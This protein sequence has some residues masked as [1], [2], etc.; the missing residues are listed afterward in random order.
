[1]DSDSD[2]DSDDNDNDEDGWGGNTLVE[3]V[4]SEYYHDKN[5]QY[6]GNNDNKNK[7]RKHGYPGPKFQSPM[8]ISIFKNI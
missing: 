1:M 5:N 4:D 2:S 6:E 8:P 7:T 3:G